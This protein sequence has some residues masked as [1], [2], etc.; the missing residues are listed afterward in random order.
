MIQMKTSSFDKDSSKGV[1]AFIVFTQNDYDNE[2][3]SECEDD[4]SELQGAFN[5]LFEK[6]STSKKLIAQ[7]RSENTVTFESIEQN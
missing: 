6:S 3:K 7:L 2:S 5:K 1:I 4:E